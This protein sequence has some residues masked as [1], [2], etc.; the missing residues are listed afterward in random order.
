MDVISAVDCYAGQVDY[1][2]TKIEKAMFDSILHF[3][4]FSIDEFPELNAAITKPK[5]TIAL[6]RIS[7]EFHL[8]LLRI[9]DLA[10]AKISTLYKGRASESTPFDEFTQQ[11][12]SA[13]EIMHRLNN[14]V[15][16]SPLAQLHI[17]SLEPLL[18]NKIT[19]NTI[20]E[21]QEPDDDALELIGARQEER[22]G[23]KMLCLVV[24]FQSSLDVV[25]RHKVLPKPAFH[26]MMRCRTWMR[27]RLA[28][29]QNYMT[30][31][32]L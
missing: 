6:V 16:Q 29:K 12:S 32:V 4:E 28:G 7:W 15:H 25:A 2:F 9:L 5:G 26:I 10:Q 18:C 11:L 27:R 21:D 23:R 24:T 8:L 20:K 1:K 3:P 22:V 19:T 14:L 17:Q 31:L 13:Q 30:G